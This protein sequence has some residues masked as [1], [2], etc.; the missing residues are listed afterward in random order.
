MPRYNRPVLNEDFMADNLLDTPVPVQHEDQ[1]DDFYWPAPVRDL[2]K[3]KKPRKRVEQSPLRKHLS[4]GSIVKYR[5]ISKGSKLYFFGHHTQGTKPSQVEVI[6]LVNG[7]LCFYKTFLDRDDDEGRLIFRSRPPTYM[8]IKHISNKDKQFPHDLVEVKDVDSDT[9][10]IVSRKFNWADYNL[11][12]FYKKLPAGVMNSVLKLKTDQ[13]NSFSNEHLWRVISI[14]CRIPQLKN[15]PIC[16]RR[17]NAIA[18]TAL[19]RLETLFR[20]KNEPTQGEVLTTMSDCQTRFLVKRGYLSSDCVDTA[21]IM[22]SAPASL[23]NATANFFHDLNIPEP[24]IGLN[25]EGIFV[26][27]HHLGQRALELTSANPG[28]AL[29]LGETLRE[30]LISLKSAK[31]LLAMKQHHIVGQLIDLGDKDNQ[32]FVTSLLRK[33]LLNIHAMKRT[34]QLSP[35][36]K[37]ILSHL[38]TVTYTTIS[39]MQEDRREMLSS[40]F[41]QDML[42]KDWHN[43]Y[44]LGDTRRLLHMFLPGPEENR[45]PQRES[46]N[47]VK[48]LQTLHDDLSREYQEHQEEIELKRNSLPYPEPPLPPVLI[49][50][51]EEEVLLGLRPLLNSAQ[52]V[53]EGG[54]MH[55]CVASYK[56]S[57]RNGST[58]L[59]AMVYPERGTVMISCHGD[60]E[61]GNYNRWNLTQ[62]YGVCNRRLQPETYGLIES[63]LQKYN[64]DK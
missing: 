2:V 21:S 61:H 36:H 63:W 12:Q 59:Y 53:R 30:K 29:S 48:Q 6:K 47:T 60:H 55:H 39:T 57:P 16:L 35:F 52:V 9:V 22:F 23:Q 10:G 11:W 31:Q 25:M 1:V 8:P 14:L 28:L 7:R 62:A 5:I 33:S 34:L 15:Y 50:E 20:R 38:P 4:T 3:P 45:Y 18:R 40:A 49:S 26:L 43:S 51:K 13:G 46:I 58:F 42:D 19:K 27:I 41:Y 54:E 37:R 17:G 56:D 24:K 64:E 44:L 32:K